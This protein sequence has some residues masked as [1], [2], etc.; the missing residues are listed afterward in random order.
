M[1]QRCQSLLLKNNH[2][3]LQRSLFSSGQKLPNCAVVLSGCGVYDGTEIQEST[4][5]LFNLAKRANVECFA[6]NIDQMHVVN[7]TNGEEMNEKRNVLIES[8]RICRGNIKDIKELNSNNFDCIL[9]PGGFGAAKNLCSFAVDGANM[10]INKDVEDVIKK[11]KNESKPMG[12]CCISPVIPAKI[13]GNDT[14]VTVGNDK[15]NENGDW[16]YAGTAQAIE[17]MGCKHIIKGPT[18][19][20]I[21]E[22]N[23][24]VTAPAYM[25]NGDPGDIFESVKSMCDA[26]LKLV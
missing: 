6:P 7:H 21:D 16:P 25:F 24:I 5:I 15:D 20:F 22:K 3:L 23:K 26:V 17:E 8:A 10:K 11:F 9:F 4:A 19:A 1:F 18:Q 13:F 12:F 2:L 14:Q